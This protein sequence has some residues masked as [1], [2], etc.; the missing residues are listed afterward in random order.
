MLV[1]SLIERLFAAHSNAGV[2]DF[3]RALRTPNHGRSFRTTGNEEQLRDAIRDAIAADALTVAQLADHVDSIEENG[4]Q[5]VFPFEITDIG[6]HELTSQRAKALK[7]SSTTRVESAY[8]AF[9]QD[10]L[11]WHVD[12]KGRLI[13]KQV[14]TASYWRKNDS[15][16]KT[17]AEKDILVR[18]RIR[19]RALNMLVVEAGKKRAEIRIARV[20]GHLDSEPKAVDRFVEFADRVTPFLDL[21]SHL[22]PTPIWNAF[23]AIARNREEVLMGWDRASEPSATLTYSTRVLGS[24]IDIRDHDDYR[25]E[26]GKWARKEL[27]VRWKRGA[28]GDPDAE[29]IFTRLSEVTVRDRPTGKIEFTKHVEPDALSYV[30]GR[31]RHFTTQASV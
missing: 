1:D 10:R 23:H 24:K 12:S 9:P 6:I 4:D 14:Y 30:I 15:E 16:S 31:I 29:Q 5:H 17:T 22:D 20:E 19:K 25:L 18:D 21:D 2:Q 3:L 26:G 27:R 8:E 13:L 7:L 28:D 11:T